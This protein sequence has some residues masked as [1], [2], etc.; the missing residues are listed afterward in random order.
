MVSHEGDTNSPPLYV[1]VRS[2]TKEVPKTVV[3]GGQQIATREIHA[4]ALE[5]EV[6]AACFAFHVIPGFEREEGAF[7]EYPVAY[8]YT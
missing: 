4:L 5:S 1:E 2:P 3:C 6:A 8:S 7:M